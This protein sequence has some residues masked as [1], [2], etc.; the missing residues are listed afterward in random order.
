MIIP[1]WGRLCDDSIITVIESSTRVL[2][3]GVS[4]V[5]TLR[6]IMSCQ[7]TLII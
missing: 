5:P 4:D 2:I 7:K 1:M 3:V 6:N